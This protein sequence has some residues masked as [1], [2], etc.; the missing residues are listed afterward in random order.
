[1]HRTTCPARTGPAEITPL[2]HPFRIGL[3]AG[4]AAAMEARRHVWAIIHTWDVPID[5]YPAALLTSDLVTDILSRDEHAAV[6]LMISWIDSE[7][8]VEVRELPGQPSHGWL[9]GGGE[10]RAGLAL[11]TAARRSL[12]WP[13]W[14]ESKRQEQ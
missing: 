3:P 7:F 2:R 13:E 6:E 4:P 9:V 11:A 8:R 10:S 14:R 12:H 5:A 1:M